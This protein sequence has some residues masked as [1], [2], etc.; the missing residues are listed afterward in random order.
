MGRRRSGAAA[1]TWPQRAHPVVLLLAEVISRQM[2]YV[3]LSGA[4]KSQVREFAFL[5]RLCVERA[6]LLDRLLRLGIL[7]ETRPE[8]PPKGSQVW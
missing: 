5:D 2:V 6:Y 8:C 3:E 1:R 7:C 4:A